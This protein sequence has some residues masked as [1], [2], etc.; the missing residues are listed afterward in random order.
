[1]PLALYM[2]QQVQSAIIRGLRERN[3]D[4]LTAYEDGTSRW[5]DT[6]LLDRATSLG[7]VMFSR[8]ED[9]CA[10]A[11]QRQA[12]AIPFNG[13]IYANQ[14]KVSIGTCVKDLEII[15]KVGE[16]DDLRNKLIYLPY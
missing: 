11:K 10:E 7:R 1:M 16:L 5:A 14:I 9:F 13:V 2:D 12:M 6:D 4:I 3:V 8:D 15:A